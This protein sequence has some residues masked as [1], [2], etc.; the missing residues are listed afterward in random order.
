MRVKTT[1]EQISTY[2]TRKEAASYLGVRVTALARW[3]SE[4]RGPAYYR[5]GR[6]ARYRVDDLDIF[7]ASRKRGG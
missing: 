2:L 7:L 5:I 6:D 1:I 3:A 4:Q